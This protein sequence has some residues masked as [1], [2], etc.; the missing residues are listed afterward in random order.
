MIKV[1]TPE[2][3]DNLRE[4][5][6]QAART[7]PAAPVESLSLEETQGLVHELQVHQIELEM[8]NEELR[9]SKLELETSWARYFDLYDLAPV[10]YFTLS[11]QGLLMDINL[12]ASDLLGRIRSNLVGQPLTRFIHPEDQDLFYRLR[13]RLSETGLLQVGELRLTRA[14]AKPFWVRMEIATM[15]EPEGEP[16]IRG[17]FSDISEHKTDESERKLLIERITQF[18]KLESLGVLAAG[19]SHNLNNVLAAILGQATLGELRAKDEQDRGA[20]QVIM[21]AC[22]RGRDVVASLLH[23]ARSKPSQLAPVELN[24]E[25]VEICELL[26]QGTC[27]HVVIVRRL[28]EEQ[29]WLEADSG[30]IN[31]A[32]MNLCINALDAMPQGGPLTLRT[33]GA[34]AGW[35]LLEVEDTGEGMTPE[36]L[37]RVMEPFFT[38]KPV[39]KGTGLGLSMS[40]GVVK[41]H[42]G[43]LSIS[44]QPGQGTV[45]RVR[46]P[47][48][49]ALPQ[50]ESVPSVSEALGKKKILLV[51]DEALIRESYVPLL[52]LSG[53]EAVAVEGGAQALA[54]LTAGE[55]PDLIILDMKMPGMDGLQT[56]ARI[57]EILPRIPVLFAS[58]Q[59][60]LADGEVLRQPH[61]AFLQKPYTVKELQLKL[62]QEGLL[63]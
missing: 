40:Y 1:Q 52:E 10:G 38:T 32:I 50:P 56:L 46:L 30:S 28:A 44:S 19:I 33:S 29:L 13:K 61:V 62:A 37:A 57:R 60:E 6:E 58:G 45:V 54:R 3:V 9:R 7:Q 4:L 18:Q 34:E 43:A 15:K 53:F 36:V 31:Q 39:G 27:G 35:I 47:R 48:I 17:V 49:A 55:I 8:Q 14:D 23:F 26:E 11:E 51:D 24:A 21:R 12:T 59:L 20:F 22:E 16:R 42:G 25:V 63:G 41:A 2:K 5:A